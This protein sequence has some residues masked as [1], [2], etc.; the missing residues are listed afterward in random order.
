MRYENALAVYP[1]YS[2]Y[3]TGAGDD[4]DTVTEDA[5]Q[6]DHKIT[7]KRRLTTILLLILA[8]I[9]GFLCYAPRMY[10]EGIAKQKERVLE[11]YVNTVWVDGSETVAFAFTEKNENWDWSDG[12]FYMS[13][14]KDG[15][16]EE[17]DSGGFE[18]KGNELHFSGNNTDLN[19]IFT[20]SCCTNE[21]DYR[22]S[23]PYTQLPT[24]YDFRKL[25]QDEWHRYGLASRSHAKN[26]ETI[27]TEAQA[28]S[29]ETVT[30]EE[31]PVTG[32]ILIEEVTLEGTMSD[33]KGTYPIQLTYRQ[34]DDKLSNCI[35]TNLDLGGKIRMSGSIVG[36]EYTFTGKDGQLKFEIR[37]GR[38]EDFYQG[39][40]VD[41][42][43]R[44]TVEMHTTNCIGVATV[45][46]AD[47][48]AK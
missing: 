18:I 19:Y 32:D 6:Y 31:L 35:Y 38:S 13:M 7:R 8:A 9:T 45:N 37:I 28:I 41:G 22:N 10:K 33:V 4:S 47:N 2:Q 15:V 40:A 14:N 16:W 23:S 42:E 44:L 29:E 46:P 48:L 34:Q 39:Y 25:P 27:G 17:V 20:P 1:Q 3:L 36:N 21:Y 12:T 11:Q 24:L 30:D 26:L 5:L 43:K